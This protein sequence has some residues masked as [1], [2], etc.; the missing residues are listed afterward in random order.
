LTEH[1]TAFAPGRINLIG[2]HT[3]YN[4]GLALAFALTAGVTVSAQALQVPW[5]EA[6]AL[7]LGEADRFS[8]DA[9]SDSV[10]LHEGREHCAPQRATDV[11][12]WRAFVRGALAE[13]RRAGVPLRGAALEISGTLARGSG[14]A[15]SAALEVALCLA[16]IELAGVDPLDRVELAQICAR[17]ENDWVGAHTGLLDQLAS[18]FGQ[19]RGAVLIDFRTLAVAP[20]ELETADHR[21]ITVD[22]GQSHV[23]AASGY[24][25]RRVECEQACA[26]LGIGT[27]R[28]ATPAMAE[29]LPEP[30]ARRARHVLSEN[31]RVLATV[32]ALADDDFDAIGRLLN[33]S[34]ASLRDDYEVSTP[35]VEAAVTR[36]REAGASG[37]RIMGG[38]FGGHVLA[39][40]GPGIPTPGG[41]IE[42][43]PA[44][45]GATILD[46]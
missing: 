16:L 28:D 39:L 1:A 3:D 32:E 4:Q 18:L 12:G 29:R 20:I 27:L 26:A 45:P 36:L 42:V 44:G 21:L 14:L 2:E 30:L 19:P 17:I 10:P 6:A 41:A 9:G 35:A 24:N 38:G 5:I 43:T 25:R 7:D 15:S 11:S 8:L 37:A 22:S 23:N 33:A 46:R 13:L 34:H 31:A 40:L